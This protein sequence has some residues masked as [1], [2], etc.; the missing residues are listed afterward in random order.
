MLS[1]VLLIIILLSECQ[2]LTVFGVNKNFIITTFSKFTKFS[3][4][5]AVGG[6]RS[7]GGI[8]VRVNPPSQASTTSVV[9]IIVAV[10]ARHLIVIIR[11]GWRPSWKV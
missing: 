3:L 10:V 1:W 11:K 2:P 9:V 8:V 7:C 6:G 4:L 5:V